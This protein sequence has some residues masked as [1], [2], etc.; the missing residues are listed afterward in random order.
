[1]TRTPNNQRKR[2]K[3]LDDVYFIFAIH[4]NS[5]GTSKG[6]YIFH[7][8][9]ELRNESSLDLYSIEFKHQI[10]DI[11]AVLHCLLRT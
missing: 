8:L 9:I 5:N 1:M 11:P 4:S 2:L 3:G 6:N 7:V 10:H